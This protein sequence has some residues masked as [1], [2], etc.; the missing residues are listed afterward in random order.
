MLDLVVRVEG[1]LVQALL[2]LTLRRKITERFRNILLS[3]KGVARGLVGKRE[4]WSDRP[5]GGSGKPTWL[6]S[7]KSG[8]SSSSCLSSLGGS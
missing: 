7:G 1:T 2:C 3:G 8:V 4:F 5:A 6:S